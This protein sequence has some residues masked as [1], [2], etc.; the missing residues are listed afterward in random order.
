MSA[1][2]Q[3]GPEETLVALSQKQTADLVGA[4]LAVNNYALTAVWD[5]LPELRSHGLLDPP[6]VVKRD[7]GALIEALE[8]AGYT[9]G[10]I[11]WIVAPRL[12]TLMQKIQAGTLDQ[13]PSAVAAGNE[14]AATD[15]LT[16]IPG[17]GP[18]VAATAWMLLTSD[19]VE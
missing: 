19:P 12:R 4:T 14:A 13:L 10:K 11:T 15:L 6:Q 18:R 9:R 2:L 5:L 1:P 7:P 17:V 8:G 3:R 16:A